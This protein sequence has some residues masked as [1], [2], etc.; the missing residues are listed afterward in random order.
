MIL[1][2]LSYKSRSFHSSIYIASDM[3]VRIF[4]QAI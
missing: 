2:S 4:Q 3:E 1:K